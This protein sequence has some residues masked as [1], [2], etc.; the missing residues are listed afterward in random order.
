[1]AEAISRFTGRGV[2]SKGSRRKAARI[3]SFHGFGSTHYMFQEPTKRKEV[4]YMIIDDCFSENLDPAAVLFM[5][6]STLDLNDEFEV[7]LQV[8]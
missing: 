1:M 5:I 8:D 6:I 2:Q 4:K 3:S 7:A